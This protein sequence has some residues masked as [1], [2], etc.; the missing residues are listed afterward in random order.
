VVVVLDGT[1]VAPKQIQEGS[2]AD[3]ERCSRSWNNATYWTVWERNTWWQSSATWH[4]LVIWQCRATFYIIFL[5]TRWVK[6][7]P[8][9]R[10]T[11]RLWAFTVA[12]W[13]KPEEEEETMGGSSRH[14]S[15][16]PSIDNSCDVCLEVRG[17]IIKTVLCCTE[18]VHSHNH[19][20]MSSLY[21]SLDWVLSHWAH[22]TVHRFCCVY[23]C[24]FCV[25]LFHTAYMS[26]MCYCNTVEWTLADWSL[27]LGP[28]FLQCFD[29][30]GWVI[31]PIKTR[32]RCYLW[33]HIDTLVNAIS[34]NNRWFSSLILTV[35]AITK[36]KPN[37]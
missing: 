35:R 36:Y 15:P 12:D 21:S 17:E 25:F 20:R 26:Y 18:A 8:V 27:M 24:I 13:A 16:S 6:T 2:A 7:H 9:S 31:W 23:L 33:F 5:Q 29:T 37:Y 1:E 22:F 32:P 28:M 10:I 14:A 3:P 11:Q 30:V 34:C 19:T 4:C